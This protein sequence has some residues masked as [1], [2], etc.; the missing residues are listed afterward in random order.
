M[1]E[2]HT[3]SVHVQKSLHVSED[4]RQPKKIDLTRMLAPY[5]SF[6]RYSQLNVTN[7]TTS[8]FIK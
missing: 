6:D 2:H 7:M 4:I 8:P 5:F 3:G 1:K